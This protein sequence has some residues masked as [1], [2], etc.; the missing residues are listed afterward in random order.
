MDHCLRIRH[1]THVPFFALDLLPK[2]SLPKSLLT[3]EFTV[4]P[5]DALYG[6]SSYASDPSYVKFLRNCLDKEYYNILLL[7]DPS[8]DCVSGDTLRPII[9]SRAMNWVRANKPSTNGSFNK[10]IVYSS[11]KSVS[12][13][14]DC[15]RLFNNWQ[16]HVH[17]LG[18]EQ[19]T[20]LT[21][22]YFL[23]KIPGKHLFAHPDMKVLFSVMVRK[24]CM[25]TV[26]AHFASN[27]PIPSSLLELWVDSS[28]EAQGS[29]MKPH[30]RKYI[31]SKFEA[32]GVS[33]RYVDNLNDEILHVLALPTFSTLEDSKK[34]EQ[35]KLEEFY[36]Y[37]QGHILLADN[38]TSG[39]V[40]RVEALLRRFNEMLDEVIQ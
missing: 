30:F 31:K 18:G 11:A 34:W 19:N 12:S 20:Y 22:M 36:K 23:A 32:G 40:V 4:D 9:Y 5:F 28:V 16:L 1:D 6:S 38:N 3:G 2:Q 26:R 33:I 13:I 17:K 29:A 27:T 24:D 14:Y 21:N 8:T 15:V 10:H 39:D 35:E 37:R 25:H 7:S